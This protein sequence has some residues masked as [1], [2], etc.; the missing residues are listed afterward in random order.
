[1]SLESFLNLKNKG[2]RLF[3]K[4][5]TA[6][7]YTGIPHNMVKFAE[8]TETN[9]NFLDSKLLN[10]SWNFNFFSNSTRTFIFKLHNNTAGYNAAVAHFVR[11]HSPDCTFCALSHNPITERELPLHLFFSC[12]HTYPVL[13]QVF[14]TLL[15]E[16]TVI[17]KQELFVNFTRFTQQ[18]NELLFYLTKLFLKYIWDCKVRKTLPNANYCHLQILGEINTIKKISPKM[19]QLF[20]MVDINTEPPL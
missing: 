18:K 3:R 13:N 5:L 12:R 7:P 19:E 11:G 8:N 10:K 15:S 2:S 14:S 17:T 20:E 9:I 1:M 16:N 4:I 6:H